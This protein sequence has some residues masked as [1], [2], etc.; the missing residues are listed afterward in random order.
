MAL[1]SPNLLRTTSKSGIIM[2]NLEKIEYLHPGV[3]HPRIVK[4]I[5]V[6]AF[7]ISRRG[8]G[9]M[10]GL[11]LLIALLSLNLFK[12]TPKSVII[13]HDLNIIEY[14][15]PGVKH[16]MIVK[17]IK[18]LASSISWRANGAMKGL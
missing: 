14:L 15:H 3:K 17:E 8:N 2:P 9:P 6:L 16:P 5:K 18:F 7:P 1:L 4:E 13:M 10:K 11:W 12:I